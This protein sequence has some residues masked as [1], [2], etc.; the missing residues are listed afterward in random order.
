MTSAPVPTLGPGSFFGKTFRDLTTDSFRF[1]GMEASVP[2][3]EVPRH[4][5]D[6]PHFILILRGLYSTE[7]R[8]QDGPCSSATLIF[9]PGGITHRDRFCKLGGKFLSISA[10]VSMSNYL[11]Q[12]SPVP[13]V[14]A[15]SSVH[16]VEGDRIANRLFREMRGNTGPTALI[17]EDLGLELVGQVAG[18]GNATHSRCVPSWLLRTKEMI[19]DCTMQEFKV[20]ELASVARVHPVY[21]ARAFRRHFGSTPGEYL[22]R[23]RLLRVQRLLVKSKLPLVEIA[24]QSGF[25]DQS[26]MTRAF[27]HEFGVSPGQYRRQFYQ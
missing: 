25:A 27:T 12:A 16:S 6:R 10:A 26:G 1:A 2:E 9:N 4:T 24:F 15:G 19:D 8:N 13:L 17:L 3:R 18:L 20:A 11:D 22:R 21:L 23:N 7:A 5:H 14:V